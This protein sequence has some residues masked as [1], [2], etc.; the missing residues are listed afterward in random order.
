MENRNLIISPDTGNR[1]FFSNYKE[2]AAAA[3][4]EISSGPAVRSVAVIA[5]SFLLT[6]TGWLSWEYHLMDQIPAGM[7]DMCTMVIG[8]LL[9]AAGIAAFAFICRRD[10]G[11][12]SAVFS[13]ALVLHMVCMVPAVISPFTAGTLIF[14]FLMNYTCGIIAGYYLTDLTQSVPGDHRASVF[15]LGYGLSILMSWLFSR[16]GGGAIYYS[17]KVLLICLILT[18]AVFAVVSADGGKKPDTEHLPEAETLRGAETIP[19]TNTAG[20]QARAGR[21]RSKYANRSFLLLAGALVLLFS[22]VNGSGFAFPA[23]DLGQSVNVELSRLFYAIGL[24]LAGIVTDTD[25]KHGAICALTALIIPF[26][27][28]ALRGGSFSVVLFWALSY[29]AFGFYAVYRVILFSDIAKESGM[30]FLS[31]MGL[32]TGR[33]GDAIGE[34]I[35]LLLG[36]RLAAIVFL[37]TVM[38]CAAVAVFF[39]LYQVLY[40]PQGMRELTEKEKFSRF[41]AEHDLSPREQDVM[42]LILENKTV[43]EIADTLSISENTVK[44][45]IRNILQKT[46]FHSRKELSSHYAER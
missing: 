6:S 27:I 42:R 18:A 44:Y 38:F 11:R 43:S 23:A 37:T 1:S 35:C 31:G 45:H 5:L 21:S 26:I 36:N 4:R 41:V 32:M 2:Q 46:G 25:R 19:E 30:L 16:I 28:L 40:I 14:G 7:S 20:R 17:E 12:I 33:V 9:Q 24:I 10:P 34:G 13:A 29:F 15:G 8:Y 39:R 3:A 22:L